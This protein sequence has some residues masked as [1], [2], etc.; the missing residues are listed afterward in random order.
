MFVEEMKTFGFH[1]HVF[2]LQIQIQLYNLGIVTDLNIGQADDA[3]NN[4]DVP[5]GEELPGHLNQL[6]EDWTPNVLLT[7]GYICLNKEGNNKV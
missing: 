3:S 4:R 1:E 6:K 2:L 5:G 7:S